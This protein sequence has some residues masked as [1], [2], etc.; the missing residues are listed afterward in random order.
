MKY[1]IIEMANSIQVQLSIFA[2][3][4]VINDVDYA[5]CRVKLDVANQPP[6]LTLWLA[7]RGLVAAGKG[8]G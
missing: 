2:D 4:C 7:S 6:S 8:L 5:L 1:G 3:R